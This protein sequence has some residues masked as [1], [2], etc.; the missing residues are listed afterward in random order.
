MSFL[1][2]SHRANPASAAVDALV[3]PAS[4]AVKAV[5]R[6]VGLWLEVAAERR[7]LRDLGY[8]RL[9]DLGIDPK[10]ADREARR[11]FWAVRNR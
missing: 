6:T 5:G 9:E 4:A 2:T 10:I 3:F 11:P 1:T 8:S 7:A